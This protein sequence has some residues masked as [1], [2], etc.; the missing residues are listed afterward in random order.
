VV[1][2]E[3][4]P[5]I[6]IGKSEFEVAPFGG[7]FVRE[8]AKACNDWPRGS[9]AKDFDQPVRSDKP[10][11][12]LSGGLD[13]VTPPVFGEEVKKAL[14]NSVH[15]VAGNIG[16]GVS[17]R[18][19]APRLIKKFVEAA[20]VA[21]LDGKCLERLPRPMFYQPMR[22]KDEPK[23]GSQQSDTQREGTGK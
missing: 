11:L 18:G 17:T 1:C 13:P 8:F 4:V 19:C 9:M 2:A 12:I 7:L 23:S 5:R 20:S 15:L 22:N 6:S 10:V 3:D 21:G 16:H 14:T